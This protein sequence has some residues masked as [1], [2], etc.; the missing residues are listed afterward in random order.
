MSDKE[1]FLVLKREL[2]SARR[3]V[4]FSV[5]LLWIIVLV[6]EFYLNLNEMDSLYG[7][8]IGAVLTTPIWYY[9][10]RR[11]KQILSQMAQL[12]T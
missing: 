11:E 5:L 1:K 2:T 12:K 6:S 3:K 7:F 4:W 10:R 8:I 9:Y